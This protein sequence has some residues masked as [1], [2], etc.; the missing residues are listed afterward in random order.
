MGESIPPCL[1]LFDN[2]KFG[3]RRFSQETRDICRRELSTIKRL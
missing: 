1:T 3:E 2:L